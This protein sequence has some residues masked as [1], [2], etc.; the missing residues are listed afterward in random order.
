[1]AL[2]D[3]TSADLAPGPFRVVRAVSPDL[4]PLSYGYGIDRLPVKRIRTRL[5]GVQPP[6]HPIW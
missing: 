3:V 2:V 4:S 5:Q 1:V 6:I